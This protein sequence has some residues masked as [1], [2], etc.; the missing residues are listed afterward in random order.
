M[1]AFNCD[2]IAYEYDKSQFVPKEV[3]PSGE[4]DEDSIIDKYSNAQTMPVLIL[5]DDIIN[6]E[7]YG[8]KKG[9]YNVIPDKYLDFLLILQS[10]KIK[11][12]IPVIQMEVFEPIEPKQ[13]KIKKMSLGKYK[14]LKEKEYRKYLKGENPEEFVLETAEVKYIPQENAYLLIYTSKNIELL[15]LIRF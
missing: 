9:F 13:E 8:L 2:L 15:G 7:G 3:Y 14:K 10:G 12:K 6:K 4:K 1:I 5:E 11:A